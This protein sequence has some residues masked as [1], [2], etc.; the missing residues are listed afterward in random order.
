MYMWESFLF[1]LPPPPSQISHVIALS[2]SSPAINM[3]L[4]GQV[5]YKDTMATQRRLFFD[6]TIY[7]SDVIRFVSSHCHFS[8]CNWQISWSP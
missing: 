1:N 2:P 8:T 3:S 4:R 5:G 7:V 6:T